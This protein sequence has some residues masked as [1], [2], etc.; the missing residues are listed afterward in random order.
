MVAPFPVHPLIAIMII[1]FNLRNYPKPGTSTLVM[2]LALTGCLVARTSLRL[3]L[4]AGVLVG[5]VAGVPVAMTPALSHA[6]TM[7]HPAISHAMVLPLVSTA[8]PGAIPSTSVLCRFLDIRLI[9]PRAV[10]AT[11][12]RRRSAGLCVTKPH[13]HCHDSRNH[14]SQ[15][16]Y[17]FHECF[18]FLIFEL[19]PISI[20]LVCFFAAAQSPL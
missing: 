5:L 6:A 19:L 4:R 10:P 14:C 8:H 11:L 15:Q 3:A 20:S 7:A 13:S 1:I 17:L 16:K 18:S 2:R 9:V 12:R